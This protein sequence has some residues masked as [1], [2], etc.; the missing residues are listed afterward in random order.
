M[1]TVWQAQHLL[2]ERLVALK[3]IHPQFTTDPVTVERFRR[4]L[5][6]AARL[7]HPHVVAAYDAEQAGPTHFL[8]MEYVEGQNLAAYLKAR[9]PLPVPEACRYARQAALGLQYAHERG[10]VHRD[11]K[12]HNLMRTPDGQIKILDFGLARLGSTI[13]TETALIP[14]EAG[15]PSAGL[16]TAAGGVMGT[17]DYLAPEQAANPG[18]ADIRADIYSLGCSLYQLLTGQVPFPGDDPREKIARHSS[19]VPPPLTALRP[20]VPPALAGVVA[21]MMAK[22]PANRPQTPAEVAEALRPFAETPARRRK[23]VWPL[24]LVGLILSAALGSAFLARQPWWRTGGPYAPPEAKVVRAIEGWGELTDPDGDCTVQADGEKLT[25]TV[26]GTPHNL[27]GPMGGMNA[28]RV[29]RPVEGDF[30]AQV[31]VSGKFRPGV[32]GFNGAGL[33]LWS[34]AWNYVRLERN[35]W[36]DNQGRYPSLTPLFEYW[37]GGRNLDP[38]GGTVV[39]FFRGRSTYLRLIRRGDQL[40]SG[41]SHDGVVWIPGKTTAIDFPRKAQVGISAVN[42]SREPFTVDFQEFN[43]VA[44]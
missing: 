7:H 6:A 20:E 1:G 37:K 9:G 14:T 30:T 25:I 2:M 10:M 11:I 38:Q 27:T 17:P 5:K 42:T 18:A 31:L 26:P 41:I 24:L 4:E 13:P 22:D 15:S 21:R 36:L 35:A 23:R 39:P 19:S 32:T 29:L 16:L 33:L 44:K 43:L 34:D 8:V 28:P 3:V 12:P 40:E